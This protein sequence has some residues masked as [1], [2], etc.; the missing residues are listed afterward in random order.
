MDSVQPLSRICPALVQHLSRACLG[1][2]YCLFGVDCWRLGMNYK[3]QSILNAL[4]EKPARSRLAPYCKLIEELRNRG[5]TYR[6]IER[7]LV[8]QC[9][10]QISRSAINNFMRAQSR[11]KAK[12]SKRQSVAP[13]D[14]NAVGQAVIADL[15]PKTDAANQNS[16]PMNEVF[17]RIAA[18]KKRPTTASST[19]KLFQYDPNEPLQIERT[20]EKKNAGE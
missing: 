1:V 11:K 17:K 13:M 18:L 3:F 4:P 2:V 14:R 10:F 9:Q 16:Q 20:I 7:I 19:S 5:C 12:P 15:N 8:D 6:E